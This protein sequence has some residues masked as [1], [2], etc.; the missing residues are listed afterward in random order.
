M[1]DGL[2]LI[3][4]PVNHNAPCCV[5]SP[6]LIG[7]LSIWLYLLSVEKFTMIWF[8]RQMNVTVFTIYHGE[9]S[10]AT[11]ATSRYLIVQAKCVRQQ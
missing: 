7:W 8:T 4:K 10:K 9:A 11:S 2:I 5:A 1:P 6:V 3:D